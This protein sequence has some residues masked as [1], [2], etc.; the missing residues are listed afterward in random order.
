LG[1]FVYVLV[2]ESSGRRYTGQ[3]GDLERRVAQHNSVEHNPAKFTS[4]HAGPWL[5]VH[6][7]EFATRAA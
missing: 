6:R 4:R 5:L 7:E 1:F 2:S 3:T